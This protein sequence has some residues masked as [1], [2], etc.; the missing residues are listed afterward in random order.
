MT[1]SIFITHCKGFGSVQASLQRKERVGVLRTDKQRLPQDASDPFLRPLFSVIFFFPQKAVFAWSHS[2]DRGGLRQP[3][4]NTLGS[5]LK[6]ME[7]WKRTLYAIPL[8]IKK[9]ARFCVFL[10]FLISKKWFG[11]LKKPND[12]LKP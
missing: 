8:K 5:T 10:I 2:H 12:S 9:K 7:M 1:S 11:L 6:Y 4:R 3:P